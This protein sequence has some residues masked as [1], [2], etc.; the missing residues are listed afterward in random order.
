MISISS[1]YRAAEYKNKIISLL[2]RNKDF[3]KLIDPKPSKCD[4]LDIADILLGGTWNI[5]GVE[6][7]EQGHIFD[8]NFVDETILDDKT[9]VFVETDI[10]MVKQNMFANFNLYISIFTPKNLVRD[11]KSVV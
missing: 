11:R 6:Y 7:K 1:L 10:D 3:V 2:I 5:N 8:Y 4:E 9:F